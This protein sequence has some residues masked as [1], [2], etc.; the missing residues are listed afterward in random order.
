MNH[1]GYISIYP[2]PPPHCTAICRVA[3][4]TI[5]NPITVTAATV[6]KSIGNLWFSLNMPVKPLIVSPYEYTYGG[7]Y[8]LVV[9]TPPP[10]TRPQTFH[11]SHDCFHI[12]YVDWYRWENRWEA[13]WALS[14]YLWAT[15]GPPNSQKFTFFL[16]CGPYMKN[17]QLIF[18]L[19]YICLLCD[20][21]LLPWNFRSPGLNI[22]A[23]QDPLNMKK[24]V[25]F[26]HILGLN[27]KISYQIVSLFCM[28][29]DMCERI[30]GKQVWLLKT[31]SG[32]PK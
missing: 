21:V 10:R 5:A 26:F 4:I 19:L 30:A 24:K 13:R 2:P 3:K 1:G 18:P 29:I 17:W 22:R 20:E 12:V 25:Y 9:V 28:Y 11:R 8:G 16:Y 31:P 15:Q 23:P 7:Y 32:P 27:L 14:D 6:S